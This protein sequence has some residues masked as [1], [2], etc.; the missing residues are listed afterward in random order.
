MKKIVFIIVSVLCSVGILQAQE[1]MEQGLKL[2]NVRALESQGWKVQH[3]LWSFDSLTIYFSAQAPDRDNYDL[4]TLHSEGWQWS[5]PQRING[6]SSDLDEWWPSISS[7]ESAIY[8]VRRTP[9]A[10][11][12]KNSYEKTQIF[13]SWQRNGVWTSAEPIIISGDEDTR[14]VMAEDNATLT[15][16][17]RAESKKHDGPWQLM[18]TRMMDEHNWTLPGLCAETPAPQPIAVISG[19]ITQTTTGLPIKNARI[20]VYDA[21]TQQLLQTAQVHK[22]TGRFRIALQKGEQYHIDITADAYSHYYLE[23]DERPLSAR[24]EEKSIAVTLSPKLD[25]RLQLYDE[26]TQESLGEEQKHLNIGAIHPIALHRKGYRDTTLVLNTEREVLFAESEIDIPMTPKKS[27]HHIDVRNS[28]TNEI[29]AEASVRMNGR[30]A[31]LDTA[32]RLEQDIT[33]QVSA[34][35]YFFYD[36]LFNSGKDEKARQ[37]QI[38]LQPIEKDFV[39]QLRA[40]QF[41]TDSYELTEDS[42]TELE[43]LLHLMQ[44]NPT[45]R[46]ELSSHTDDRGT[47]RYNDRLSSLRGEAVAQW[48]ISRGIATER[49]EA[50]GYGKRKPLVPND[51]DENRA[52]NRR[53]EIKVI[54]Y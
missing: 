3:S 4:F 39:L 50:V 37:I 35:G 19:S 27:R 13:R 2:P 49:I 12:E 8:F 29:V 20:Q 16:Y 14:P 22:A 24:T 45:L 47:D 51:S 53:V 21:I 5:E 40:I 31:A 9:A 43:Q 44:I 1:S 33:L 10:A 41:A 54:D 52:L 32:L 48:L 46:I 15:F 7:D 26:E 30:S 6:L 36:T 38:L 23:R 25:I 17:R 28:K 11:G 42:N 18:S 34:A